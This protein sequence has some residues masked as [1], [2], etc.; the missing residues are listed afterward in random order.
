MALWE[1]IPGVKIIGHMVTGPC[2][3]KVQEYAGCQPS[4]AD[5]QV[6]MA[7]IRQCENCVRD[8]MVDCLKKW[9]GFS[10]PMDAV[11][12]LAGGV[13]GVAGPKIAKALGGKFLGLAA[14][15]WTGIGAA[16]AVLEVVDVVVLITKAFWIYAAA[17]KA[18]AQYCKCG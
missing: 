14:G 10:L 11:G 5:C 17:Q 12:F 6:P 9:L 18:K 2:G 15:A 8:K 4:A 16:I 3:V 1:W 13:I 7:A